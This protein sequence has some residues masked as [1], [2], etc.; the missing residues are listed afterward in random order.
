MISQHSQWK[1]NDHKK[2]KVVDWLDTDATDDFSEP[3]DGSTLE[4]S[5][6]LESS[7]GLQRINKKDLRRIKDKAFN[8]LKDRSASSTE[9]EYHLENIVRAMSNNIDWLNPEAILD[10]DK[11]YYTDYFKPLPLL[12]S[13]IHP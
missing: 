8:L 1:N 2:L 7:M 6:R 10:T 12:G 13:A 4:F 3:V 11:P 5:Q 9:L